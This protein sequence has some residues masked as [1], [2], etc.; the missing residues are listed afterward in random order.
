MRK[1]DC[2]K[3]KLEV[4][5]QEHKKN[6]NK[7]HMKTTKITYWIAT[8]L[9]SLAMAFGGYSDLVQAPEMTAGMRHLGYP[10]Y[11]MTILGIA[12]ILGVIALLVPGFKTIKEWAY[13]GFTFDILGAAWSHTAV[14]GFATAIAPLV[15]LG[16]LALSYVMHQKLVLQIT[17]KEAMQGKVALS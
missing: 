12:K 16:I 5:I 17:G 13:A 3:K 9:F 6:I 11:V 2:V 1:N 4:E 15:L 14:D 10:D 8:G 7:T